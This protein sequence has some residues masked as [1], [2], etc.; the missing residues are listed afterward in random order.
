MN[1][2]TLSLKRIKTELNEINNN[3]IFGLSIGMVDNDYYHLKAII[4][5]T[6]NNSPFYYKFLELEIKLSENYPFKEPKI[7][8]KT[9]IFH[10]N[11]LNDK[12]C[13]DIIKS[14]KWSPALTLEKV[15]LSIVS[16]LDDANPNDPLNT[17]AANLYINNRN[18]YNK[19][20]RLMFNKNIYL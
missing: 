16:L 6:D 12:I 11:F 4:V 13:L 5:N 20:V 17:D 3:N 7:I 18:E 2:K 9:P 19:R 1:N 10:P 15:L 14:D 8:L